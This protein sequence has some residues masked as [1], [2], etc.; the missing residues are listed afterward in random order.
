[1][2]AEVVKLVKTDSTLH[3][4]IEGHTDNVASTAYNQTL[5]AGRALSVQAALVAKHIDGVRLDA[6]GFGTTR[7]IAN[8]ADEAGRMKN[9]R[10]ELVK[11]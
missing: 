2:I 8:N 4:R 1:M 10:V 5:S 9:R 6:K 3:L 11:L 7:P